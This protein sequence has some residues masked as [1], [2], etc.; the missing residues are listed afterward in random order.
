MF[1]VEKKFTFEASHALCNL[2]E[3]HPCMA[4]HGHSYKLFVKISSLKLNDQSFIIDFG[5]LKSFK[6][7]VVDALFDHAFIT[8]EEQFE[9]LPE[10]IKSKKVYIMPKK[11]KN[12]SA[13]NMCEHF[14]NLF[15]KFLKRKM[16]LFNIRSI[17]IKLFETENNCAC[18]EKE[19]Y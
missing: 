16:S 17:R 7:N 11:Y 1:S 4:V 13:E 6:K 5:E 3:K 15:E 18:F 12:T 8:T 14:C 10:Y 19:Y 9:I 2:K